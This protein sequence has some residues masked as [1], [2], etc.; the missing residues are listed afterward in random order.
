MPHYRRVHNKII[1]TKFLSFL[2]QNV[3]CS[4]ILSHLSKGEVNSGKVLPITGNQGL[5]GV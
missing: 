1:Q 2:C 3:F 4:S 5:E